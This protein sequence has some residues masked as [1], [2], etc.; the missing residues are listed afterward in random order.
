MRLLIIDDHA[1][2]RRGIQQILTDSFEHIETGEAMNAEEGL[3]LIRKKQWD[4]VVLD[5]SMPGRILARRLPR[6][7][8]KAPMCASSR[9]PPCH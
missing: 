1:V 2:V 5:I 3:D 8:W 9:M 4:I 7:V 6:H